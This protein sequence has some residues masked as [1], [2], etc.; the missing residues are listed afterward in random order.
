MAQVRVETYCGVRLGRRR[1]LYK[2]NGL[3]LCVALVAGARALPDAGGG[4]PGARCGGR[5]PGGN[6]YSIFSR[7]A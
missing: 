6:F 4:P 5:V 3:T 2:R 1:V 7:T